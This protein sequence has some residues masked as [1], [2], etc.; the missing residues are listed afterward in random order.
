MSAIKSCL[1][2]ERHSVPMLSGCCVTDKNCYVFKGAY[3]FQCTIENFIS[4]NYYFVQATWW[5]AMYMLYPL[6]LKLHMLCYGI[7][8]LM[9]LA[10]GKRKLTFTDLWCEVGFI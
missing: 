8:Y 9:F 5:F 4:I 3:P 7:L 2:S 6:K 10:F 1:S